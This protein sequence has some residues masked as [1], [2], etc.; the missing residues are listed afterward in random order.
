MDTTNTFGFDRVVAVLN[1]LA[2]T[3][4]LLAGLLAVV[5]IIW[6]GL[7]MATAKGDPKVFDDAK[8]HLIKAVIGAMIIFGVYTIINTIGGAAETLTQ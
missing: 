5:M 4:L 7:R 6:F 2:D 8:N 3:A 1:Y